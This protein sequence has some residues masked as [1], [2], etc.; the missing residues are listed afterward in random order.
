MSFNKQP[1]VLPSFKPVFPNIKIRS[2]PPRTQTPAIG[3]VYPPSSHSSLRRARDQ[4]TRSWNQVPLRESF[5]VPILALQAATLP[6]PECHH[7]IRVYGAAEVL[8]EV[9]LSNT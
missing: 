8:A 1:P 9:G 5:A 7:V 3:A 4:L 2:P 6:T